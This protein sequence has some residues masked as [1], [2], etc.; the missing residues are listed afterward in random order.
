MPFAEDQ[1]PVGDLGLGGEHEPFRISV[2]ARAAG[3]DLHGLDAGPGQDRVK[4]RGELP[5]PVTDQE[6]QAGGAITQIHQQVADLL[7]GP[8]PVRVRGDTEDVHVTGAD[9]HDEQA[10]QA[11]QGHRAVHVE[12]IGGEHRGCLRVQELPPRRAGAPFR[13]RGNLP[14]LEDPADG[15]CADPVAELEQ[16][17][18][19][20]LVSPAVVLGGKPLDERGDLGADRRPSYPVRVGPL[21]GDQAAVPA[22]D[23]AGGDEPVC[24]QFRL[25]KAR[26]AAALDDWDE[27]FATVRE[28]G[29]LIAHVPRFAVR[30]LVDAAAARWH[31]EVGQTCQAEEL[32]T[33]LPDGGPS[34]TLLRAR[35]DLARGRFDAGQARLRRACPGTMRDRLTSELHLARAA[36]ESGEDAAAHVTVA[37]GLAAPERLTR[38]F[39]EEGAAVARLARAAAAALGTKSGT[40]PSVALGSPP[41]PAAPPASQW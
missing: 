4:R 32:I 8:R 29:L 22:Q 9:L 28:A 15:G 34:H 27:V 24:S 5:G 26:A 10:V 33:T 20:P 6:P 14:G 37:V 19:D 7:C 41:P 30:R 31:L 2:R 16:L 17:A 36:I 21:A 13:C 12:E 35:L 11:P 18:L 3:R 38:V 23:G 1:H 39:L 25:E 40:D